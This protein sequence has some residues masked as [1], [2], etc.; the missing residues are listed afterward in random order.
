[1]IAIAWYPPEAILTT[2]AK[3]TFLETQ[4]PNQFFQFDQNYYLQRQKGN[5]CWTTL[6]C[7]F[8]PRNFTNWRNCCWLSQT[9]FVYCCYVSKLSSRISSRCIKTGTCRDNCDFHQDQL[10]CLHWKAK[11]SP[12]LVDQLCYL[13]FDQIRFYPRH[14][15]L[16]VWSQH[17]ENIRNSLKL[18]H[19]EFFWFVWVDWLWDWS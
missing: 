15:H 13:Q 5:H 10:K 4:I 18:C 3:L 19:E 6:K 17:C 9:Q 2:F 8:F 14:R 12:V 11:S 1:M 16:K 7:V